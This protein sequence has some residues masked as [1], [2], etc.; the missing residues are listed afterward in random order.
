MTSRNQPVKDFAQ[1]IAAF[2]FR[3][4][5]ARDGEGEWGFITDDTAQRVLS[6]SFNDGG[7]LG[8]NYGPPSQESGTGWRI[9]GDPWSLKTADAVRKALYAHPPVWCGKGWR[10]LTT[11]DQHLSQYGSSSRFAEFAGTR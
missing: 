8:G 5:I 1:R 4:F 10:Y 7:S 6:F 9:D 11:V 2:G 3:V